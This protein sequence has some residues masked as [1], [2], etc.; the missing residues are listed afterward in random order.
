[1][2]FRFANRVATIKPSKTLAIT[3]KAKELAA[4]GMDVINFGGGEPDLDTPQA[5]KEAAITAIQSGFTKY[6]QPSGIEE[7]KE[8]IV[9]KFISDNQLRYEK[10][11]IL[12]SCGAK[13]SLYNIAQVLL[14][15]GD[16][17][18]IPAPYWVSYPEQV[19]LNEATPVIVKTGEAE[20]FRIT[21]DL[22]KRHITPKTKALILN[23]PANPTGS[24]YQRKHLE[25]IAE[26]IVEHKLIVISDEIYEK[27]IYD[28]VKH[29]SIASLSKELQAQT[30]VVNGV[31]KSH[32]MT[33]W[34]IGYAAG[35]SE[36]I[37]KMASVQSQSTS[38][39]NSIA[40]KA[41]V[42]ALRNCESQTTAMVQEFDRRRQ[43]MMSLL[44]K[45]PSISCMRPTG[46]FYT[47]PKVS[48]YYGKSFQ[49]KL[50]R[51]SNDLTAYLLEKAHVT[52]V[53]GEAFGVDDHLR[54]SYTLPSEKIEAGLKR[55]GEALAQLK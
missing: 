18:L 36:I 17:V 47:F 11:Q 21:A 27:F 33:G 19:L 8:A 53:P 6:T 49:G 37:A 12:V 4:Q 45:I 34:R 28:G 41:A 25:G 50:I 55:I 5:A 39:P 15:R 14:D 54:L 3:A 38:N 16:E 42:T 2:N 32:A 46:A 29:T 31:S 48:R 1:M 9:A 43:R 24:V 23:S 22:L 10:Q 7:L 30:I 13:H 44:N 26:V 51:D 52:V 20:E 40:Q 35:P